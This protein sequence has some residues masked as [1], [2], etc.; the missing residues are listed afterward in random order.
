MG[1]L[2]STGGAPAGAPFGRYFEFGEDSVDVEIGIPVAEPMPGLP[3]LSVSSPGEIGN[4]ELPGG[5]VAF[6]VHRGNYDELPDSWAHLR[7]WIDAK[8][9]EVGDGPWESYV[10]DPHDMSDIENVRTEIVWPIG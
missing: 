2:Q 10:D 1:R 5:T 9:H 6:T 8:G 3:S 7:E 4:S